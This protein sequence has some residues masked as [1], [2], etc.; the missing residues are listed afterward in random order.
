MGLNYIYEAGK[1]VREE[2]LPDDQKSQFRTLSGSE[3]IALLAA[4]LGFA[5]VDQLLAK[6]KAIEALL[7]KAVAVDRLSGNTPAAIAF[8]KTGD[9]ALT[10]QELADIDAAWELY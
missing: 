4:V 5:R 10:D 1:P 6:S 8:L 9:N 2:I 3:F 7:V